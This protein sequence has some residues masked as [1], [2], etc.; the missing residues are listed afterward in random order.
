MEALPASPARRPSSND[1]ARYELTL[2]NAQ[3]VLASLLEQPAKP[4]VPFNVPSSVRKQR[5]A[6]SAPVLAGVS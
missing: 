1:V 2:Q 4:W 3:R 6:D 5:E